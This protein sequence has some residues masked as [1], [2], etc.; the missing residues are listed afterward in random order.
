MKAWI[1]SS[2]CLRKDK[3]FV[4]WIVIGTCCGPFLQGFKLVFMHVYGQVLCRRKKEN[5]ASAVG[6][7]FIV[8]TLGI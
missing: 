1:N 7:K 4:S 3:L 6:F 8:V 2:T 5:K